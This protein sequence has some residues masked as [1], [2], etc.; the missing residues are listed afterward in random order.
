MALDRLML[1]SNKFASDIEK[2]QKSRNKC[3]DFSIFHSFMLSLL[4]QY[5]LIDFLDQPS[6]SSFLNSSFT[7]MCLNSLSAISESS[8]RVASALDHYQCQPMALRHAA[9]T[10]VLSKHT[11]HLNLPKTKLCHLWWCNWTSTALQVCCHSTVWLRGCIFVD[12]SQGEYEH[13]NQQTLKF[14]MTEGTLRLFDSIIG[15]GQVSLIMSIPASLLQTSMSEIVGQAFSSFS[16]N[17]FTRKLFLVRPIY[18]L[19]AFK[20]RWPLYPTFQHWFRDYRWWTRTRTSRRLER[21]MKSQRWWLFRRTVP[22]CESFEAVL[23]QKWNSTQFN[24][25]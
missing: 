13:S 23:V 10:T 11:F 20:A 6:L 19:V 15:P 16:P 4:Q 8:Q 12:C 5:I 1:F 2:W 17:L 14:F 3:W 21:W 18:A 7:P 25:L 22:L 24:V 9:Q